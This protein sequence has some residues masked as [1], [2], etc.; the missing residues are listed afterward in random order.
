MTRTIQYLSYPNP[1][2]PRFRVG[3]GYYYVDSQEDVC[4]FQFAVSRQ[5]YD[6]LMQKHI[7]PFFERQIKLGQD[8]AL[9]ELTEIGAKSWEENGIIYRLWIYGR[10]GHTWYVPD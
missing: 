3:H 5:E 4:Q 6:A 7:D 2:P 10:D 1:R 9:D 8:G